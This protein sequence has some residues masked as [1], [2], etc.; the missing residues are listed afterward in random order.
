MGWERVKREV[1]DG[2]DLVTR[3][4]DVNLETRGPQRP[5]IQEE[6]PPA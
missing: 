2:V 1:K 6:N 4:L 5:F 3:C